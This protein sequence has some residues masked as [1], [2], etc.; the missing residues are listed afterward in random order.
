MIRTVPF[1]SIDM[2]QGQWLV[3]TRTNYFLERVAE[4]VKRKR[5]FICK[6]NNRLFL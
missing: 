1:E 3:L 6:R 5:T 2:S 4:E